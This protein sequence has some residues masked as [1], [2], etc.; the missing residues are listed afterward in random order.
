MKEIET[1]QIQI[2]H[3]IAHLYTKL[4]YLSIL[5]GKRH[6]NAI[7]ILAMGSVT[8]YEFTA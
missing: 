6:K 8:K 4:N 1:N 3:D 5:N 7:L 2:V